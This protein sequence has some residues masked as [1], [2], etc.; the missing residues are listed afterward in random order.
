MF[1]VSVFSLRHRRAKLKEDRSRPGTARNS[2]VAGAL[3]AYFLLVPGEALAG[4]NGISSKEP[5][6]A[7]S[8]KRARR[9]EFDER[10]I[11]GQSLKSGAIYL[12]ERKD[13]EIQ[14]MVEVREDFRKEL[15]A[16]LEPSP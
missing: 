1:L 5:G 15:L 2:W 13:S 10:L 7:V 6:G 16:P 12:F 3:M 14:S 4:D 11:M 8:M 9:L